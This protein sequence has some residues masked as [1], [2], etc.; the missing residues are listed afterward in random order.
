MKKLL[1]QPIK[2]ELDENIVQ[3]IY[4]E[5]ILHLSKE[6][7]NYGVLGNATHDHTE[8]NM[9]CGDE[10]RVMM[11]FTEDSTMCE[12]ISFI[13]FGC[14]VMKASASIMTDA[15][16]GCTPDEIRQLAE[17]FT[18]FLHNKPHSISQ[19]AQLRAFEGV[20]QFPA[21]IKCVLLPWKAVTEA[22]AKAKG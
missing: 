1:E 22:L 17:S 2:T 6:P 14:A 8:L 9:L 4:H 18:N 5:T 12:E 16:K 20:K 10:V 13:G 15:L 21:R 11:R 7:H 19:D 3:N